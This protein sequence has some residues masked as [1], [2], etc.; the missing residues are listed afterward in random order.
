MNI[1]K[2]MMLSAY[3]QCTS[4]SKLMACLQAARPGHF[5]SALLPRYQ[6]VTL[7]QELQNANVDHESISVEAG[8]MKWHVRKPVISSHMPVTIREWQLVLYFSS[9]GSLSALS[10]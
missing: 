8:I 10:T 2:A 7:Y 5:K 9:P 1:I 3:I 6:H 4:N